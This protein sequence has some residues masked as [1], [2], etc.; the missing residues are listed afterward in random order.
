M[1]SKFHRQWRGWSFDLCVMA[2]WYILMFVQKNKTIFNLMKRLRLS[3]RGA[4]TGKLRMLLCFY[5]NLDSKPKETWSMILTMLY[6]L[7]SDQ[8]ESRPES[9]TLPWL[10]QVE[11][12]QMGTDTCNK[13]D[14]SSYLLNEW[15][16]FI[17]CNIWLIYISFT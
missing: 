9:R 15:L 17:Y 7:L 13:E 6:Y 5:G 11:N 2:I 4:L 3:Q 14:S 12:Y 10:S 1:L 16:Q 8:R